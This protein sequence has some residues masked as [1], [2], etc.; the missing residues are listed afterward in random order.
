MKYKP[1][2]KGR[3]LGTLINKFKNGKLS[4]KLN[5]CREIVTTIKTKEK[6]WVCSDPEEGRYRRRTFELLHTIFE[7][8]HSDKPNGEYKL[9]DEQELNEM[10]NY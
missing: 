3:D 10:L 8:A 1:T 2:E 4:N 9:V 5:K 6:L 7:D